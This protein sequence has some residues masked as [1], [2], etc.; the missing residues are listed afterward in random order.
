MR[1]TI[2]LTADDKARLAVLAERYPLAPVHR[3]TRAALQ[4]GLRELAAAPADVL[5]EAAIQAPS[6]DR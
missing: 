6:T 3:L 5:I 4:R 2:I 1:C